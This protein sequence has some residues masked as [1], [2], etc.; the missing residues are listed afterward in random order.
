MDPFFYM[1]DGFRYAFTGHS[2]AP[3]IIGYAIMVVGNLGLGLLAWAL[4]RSG[5]RL[6]A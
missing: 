3:L 4:F 2:D 1:I 6:R 5:Y